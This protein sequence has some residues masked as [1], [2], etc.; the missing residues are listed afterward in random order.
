MST[1]KSKEEEG[2]KLGGSHPEEEETETLLLGFCRA[3]SQESAESCCAWITN[4]IQ[5]FASAREARLVRSSYE[6]GASQDDYMSRTATSLEKGRLRC[7]LGTPVADDEA[8]AREK[9]EEEE[10]VHGDFSRTGT[11]NPERR[12]HSDITPWRG[13]MDSFYKGAKLSRCLPFFFCLR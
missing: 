3:S 10:R 5:S 7:K 1:T 8:A 4:P 13:G 6:A 9:S 12:H 2:G 11:V